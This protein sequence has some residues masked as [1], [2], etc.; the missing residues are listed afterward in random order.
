MWTD[1]NIR[2][3]RSAGRAAKDH[4]G[5]P[6]VVWQRANTGGT[7]EDLYGRRLWGDG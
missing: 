1:E 7:G 6:L 5:W 4:D 2:E 3:K